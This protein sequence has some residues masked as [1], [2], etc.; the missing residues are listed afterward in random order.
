[1]Y[2]KIHTAN[3]PTV[4]SNLKLKFILIFI[5]LIW[6]SNGIAEIGLL[7]LQNYHEYS[8]NLASSG[9]PTTDQFRSIAKAGVDYV[10]NLAPLTSTGAHLNEQSIVEDLNMGY[11][12]IPVNWGNPTVSD[13]KNFLSII[14]TNSNK[15]I[16]VHCLLN[17]RAS[18]FVYLSK[19]L[20]ENAD[21]EREYRVLQKIWSANRG[22]ELENMH[23]WREFL[24]RA[25][26]ELN[27]NKSLE[28]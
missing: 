19:V 22:Y 10:I 16:L 20:V 21:K 3:Y 5:S 4:N 13:L 7:E 9:Q 14:K 8:S 27:P 26:K 12:H 15:T 11:S 24:S 28:R 2:N 1:M 23:H 17:A 18:A 25:E 6:S